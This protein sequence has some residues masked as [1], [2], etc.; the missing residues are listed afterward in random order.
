[1]E[2][3]KTDPWLSTY[4]MKTWMT[5]IKK[6]TRHSY[7]AKMSHSFI[8]SSNFETRRRKRK[9]RSSY[10]NVSSLPP[11][12]PHLGQTYP[13]H[14]VLKHTLLVLPLMWETR[15]SWEE[16]KWMIVSIPWIDFAFYFFMHAILICNFHFQIFEL[17]HIIRWFINYN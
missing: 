8:H 9:R 6:S 10:E 17:C 3:T 15:E 11:L 4:Q 1:M 16:P 2:D 7:E 12:P 14:P 5:I 13:Q